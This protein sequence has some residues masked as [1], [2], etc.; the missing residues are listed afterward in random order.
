MVGMLI[1]ALMLDSR[2]AQSIDAAKLYYFAGLSQA[3]VAQELGVSRPTVSKLL[4]HARDKGFVIFSLHDPREGADALVERLKQRF[5]LL[6]ARVVRP[7]TGD[8]A[9]LLADL[10][11]AG[12]SLLEELVHDDM[13]VG[14]SWGNTMFAVAEHLRM[15][16]L[17]GV[18]VIQLKGGHSHSERNTRDLETL[19]RFARAFNADMHILPLPVI[20]DNVEAKRLVE[21]D[22]HIAGIMRAGASVDLAVFTV[23]DVQRESLLLNLGVLSDAEVDSL[24]ETAVGDV[25]SRFYDASGQVADS[26]IDARTVGISVADLRARPTRVLVAGGVDKTLAIQVALD[27]G[28]ATHL[29]IDHA[30]AER[31]WDN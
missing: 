9:G 30:T 20:L 19:S 4:Q 15:Q 16:N 31:V 18:H 26:L 12:A 5:G 8:T 25:C 21:Q 11:A 14:I 24:L 22:R 1:L 27:M 3:E 17:S 6:D 29:V 10:G 13:R 7:A 28:I 2:D 23:G